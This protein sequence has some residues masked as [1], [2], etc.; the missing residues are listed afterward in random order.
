VAR[1]HKPGHKENDDMKSLW[2]EMAAEFM[3]EDSVTIATVDCGCD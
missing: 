1:F 3:F 2:D